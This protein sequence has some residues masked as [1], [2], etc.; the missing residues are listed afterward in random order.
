MLQGLGEFRLAHAVAGFRG[1]AVRQKNCAGSRRIGERRQAALDHLLITFGDDKSFAR[2]TDRGRK[3]GRERQAPVFFADMRHGRRRPG[4]GRGQRA[5]QGQARQ[6]APG[7]IEIHVGAGRGRRALAPVDHNLEAVG[8]AMQQPESAAAQ[9]GV[10]RIDHAQHRRH[11]HRGIEGISTHLQNRMPR[12]R[13][14][15]MTAGNR[16]RRQA[17]RRGGRY[18]REQEK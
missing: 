1:Q 8:G 9:A 17:R 6:R 7:A 5:V 3:R 16:R 18:D 11:R 15:R 12:L 10:G 2:Q 14:E 13:R 4:D